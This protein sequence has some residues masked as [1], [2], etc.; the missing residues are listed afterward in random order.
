MEIVK[1]KD[2]GI[3]EVKAKEI[4]AI[5]QPMLNKMVELENKYNELKNKEMSRELIQ[6]AKYLRLEYVKVRIG[7]AK[8]HKELKAESLA[9]GRVIDGWKNAQLMSAKDPEKKL[10]EIENF[11]INQEKDKIKVI[12]TSRLEALAKLGEINLSGDTSIMLGIM[13]DNAWK[14][15]FNGVK[16]GVEEKKE[17]ER[18]IE[19]ERKKAEEIR[20]LYQTRKDLLR[21]YWYSMTSEEQETKLASMDKNVFESLIEDLKERQKIAE[22]KQEALEKEN[23]SLKNEALIKSKE[24]EEIKH[25]R[26]NINFEASGNCSEERMN[27]CCEKN[28]SYTKEFNSLDVFIV[29]HVEYDESDFDLVATF[30]DKEEAKKLL[31]QLE[32]SAEF[33]HDSEYFD[34]K[35]LSEIGK[36]NSDYDQYLK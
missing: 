34:I 29:I 9:Y 23:E 7:T 30:T 24:L 14:A 10:K 18:K 15:Y 4:Q 27:P 36:I 6:E 17:A 16:R 11:Y 3:Q 31:N 8:I 32:S 2:Y 20:I 1:A 33:C 25:D 26:K 13:D 19:Q 28:T 5:F 22:E 35:Q 12:I 21:P